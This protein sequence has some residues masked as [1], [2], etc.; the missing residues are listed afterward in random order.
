MHSASTT[1]ASLPE[2][3]TIAWADFSTLTCSLAKGTWSSGR[4]RSRAKRC[5]VSGATVHPSFERKRPRSIKL[6]TRPSVVL[7]WPSTPAANDA[8]R[9]SWHRAPPGGQIEQERVFAGVSTAAPRA[10]A[11][12]ARRTEAAV[13]SRIER[14][15]SGLLLSFSGGRCCLSIAA[16]S[17]SPAAGRPARKSSS[18]YNRGWRGKWSSER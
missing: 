11:A 13:A 2:S 4:P 12:L 10:G 7:I 3:V 9:R 1:D 15:W 14:T 18:N 8:H 5:H 6:E 16:L 17:H